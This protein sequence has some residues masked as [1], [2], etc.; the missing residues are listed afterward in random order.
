MDDQSRKISPV[1]GLIVGLVI[2]FSWFAFWPTDIPSI[3]FSPPPVV[4]FIEFSQLRDGMT[5]TE[6]ATVIGASGTLTAKS[7]I[8]G[9][10]T[11]SYSWQNSDGSNAIVMFQNDKLIMKAQAGLR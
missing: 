6:A 5:Y 10:S 11:I 1:V 4:S 8:A 2:A 7:D 9:I 3:P